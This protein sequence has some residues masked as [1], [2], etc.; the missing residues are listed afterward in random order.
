[1]ALAAAPLGNRLDAAVERH[2]QG[3]DRNLRIGTA[4]LARQA[5]ELA[6]MLR[7]LFLA[8]E[9]GAE[10]DAI[11]A[12]FSVIEDDDAADAVQ[13]DREIEMVPKALRPMRIKRIRRAER[14]TR[15]NH[16]VVIRGKPAPFHIARDL[17]GQAIIDAAQEQRFGLSGAG[18]NGDLPRLDHF[19][20]SIS[21]DADAK[22]SRRRLVAGGPLLGAE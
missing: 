3:F 9:V 21:D 19:L 5:M 17:A 15:E 16:M 6:R 8:R 11:A 4:N 7:R 22:L 14:G 1:H 2:Q 10:D 12:A 18:G 13:L 20:L